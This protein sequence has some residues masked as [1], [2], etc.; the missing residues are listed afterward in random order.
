M[1]VGYT[2]DTRNVCQEILLIEPFYGGSHKQL[3]D[4]LANDLG[5]KA[6]L[7]TLP[8]KK[9]HWRA[10]TS[11]L[12]F[13]RVIPKGHKFRVLFA[14]SVLSLAELVALRPDLLPLKKILYFHENQLLYPVRKEQERDFQYGY[15]QIVSSLVA[16]TVVFNSKFNQDSFLTTISSFFKKM[17]D[18][19]PKGIPEELKCKCR[20]IYFPLINADMLNGIERSTSVCKEHKSMNSK[21]FNDCEIIDTG[22]VCPLE[23]NLNFELY[24]ERKECFSKKQNVDM[25]KTV[26]EDLCVN[27][28]VNEDLLSNTTNNMDLCVSTPVNEDLLSNTTNNMDLRVSTPVNVDLFSNKTNNEDLFSN[29]TKDVDPCVNT[30]V[31]VDVCSNTPNNEDLFSNTTKDVDLCVNTPVI[32]SSGL[33]TVRCRKL[34]IVWPHRW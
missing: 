27:T 1:R 3:V 33:Q 8:A 11:A 23:E 10:R 15:N 31:N 20:V 18:Y 21:Y 34:H 16:D 17:P 29:T 24:S 14:S 9:W 12:H 13:S 30:P 25:V 4:T 7:F 19:R 5:R 32:T 28:P 22:T 26:I 6:A 2:M